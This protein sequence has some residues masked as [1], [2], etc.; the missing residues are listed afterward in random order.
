MPP[1]TLLIGS[2]SGGADSAGGCAADEGSRVSGDACP[3]ISFVSGVIQSFSMDNLILEAWMD[4]ARMGVDSYFE[5]SHAWVKHDPQPG[6]ISR[7]DAKS[8]S[9]TKGPNDPLTCLCDYLKNIF[10]RS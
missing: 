8:Q 9:K 1:A 3:T 5:S 4:F 6:R 10:T 2:V 7:E